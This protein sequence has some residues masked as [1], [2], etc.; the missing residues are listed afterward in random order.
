MK[1]YILQL[2]GVESQQK[3]MVSFMS[4]SRRDEAERWLAGRNGA[5]TK[6]EIVDRG[7]LWKRAIQWR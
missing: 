6:W 5:F 4:F 1:R 3:L 7:P 2:R